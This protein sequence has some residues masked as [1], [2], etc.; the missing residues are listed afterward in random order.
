MTQVGDELYI[1][2]GGS[3]Y[4]TCLGKAPAKKGLK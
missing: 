3:E 1:Y 4:Y 2:Y